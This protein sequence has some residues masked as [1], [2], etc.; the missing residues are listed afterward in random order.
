MMATCAV[1]LIFGSSENQ[2]FILIEKQKDD[3]QNAH[4]LLPHYD[5]NKKNDENFSHVST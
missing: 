5:V 1:F 4:A 3:I 2:N